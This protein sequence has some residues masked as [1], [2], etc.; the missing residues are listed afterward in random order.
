MSGEVLKRAIH[1]L[2]QVVAY[3]DGHVREFCP[4]VIGWKHGVY[5]VLTWQFGGYSSQDLPDE[6]AWRCF[7]VHELENVTLRDGPWHRGWTTGRGVQHCVDV[8]EL[9]VAEAY[10]AEVRQTSPAR[11]PLRGSPP[12][13]PRTRR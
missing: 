5:H 12:R 7:D 6:G 2:R 13:G 9:A 1:E 8:V 3:R 4:H 10:A 11:T